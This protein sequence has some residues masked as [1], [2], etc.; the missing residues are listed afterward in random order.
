MGVTMLS[1]CK[2]RPLSACKV[3]RVAEFAVGQQVLLS[4]THMP[5]PA[6]WKLGQHWVSPFAVVGREGAIAYEL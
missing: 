4:I 3:R 1:A 2:V 5:V 6:S